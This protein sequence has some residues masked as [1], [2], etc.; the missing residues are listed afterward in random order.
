MTKC[1]RPFLLVFFP[2]KCSVVFT[3]RFTAVSTG[4]TLTQELYDSETEILGESRVGLVE[5]RGQVF[6]TGYHLLDLSLNDTA[7]FTHIFI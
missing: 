7:A 5:S 1:S 6:F 4:W 2:L 3:F